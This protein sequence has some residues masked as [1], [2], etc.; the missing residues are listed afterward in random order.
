[1][2]QTAEKKDWSYEGAL[3][4][5]K[6]EFEKKGKLLINNSE[7]CEYAETLPDFF[8][9]YMTDCGWVKS[10][11][12][13]GEKKHR[14]SYTWKEKHE[15]FEGTREYI[16]TKFTEI[17]RKIVIKNKLNMVYSDWNGL[18]NTKKTVLYVG[19]KTEIERMEIREQFIQQYATSIGKSHLEPVLVDYSTSRHLSNLVNLYHSL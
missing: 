1:M 14:I 16:K 19:E 8:Y 3:T 13:K 5:F 6:S 10:G 4:H 17:N 18:K 12:N 11:K 2:E 9:I 15:S 7:L